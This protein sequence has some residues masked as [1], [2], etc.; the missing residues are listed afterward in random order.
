MKRVCNVLLILVLA[1]NTI[2][3][4][5]GV[6]SA[7]DIDLEK[8]TYL[9]LGKVIEQVVESNQLYQFTQ[10]MILNESITIQE[11]T[12]IYGEKVGDAVEIQYADT[13]I[14]IPLN[15]LQEVQLTESAPE[16]IDSE[17]IEGQVDSLK[18]SKDTALYSINP[19]EMKRILITEEI[20]YPTSQKAEGIGVVYLGNVEFYLSKEDRQVV[21][22][23][24]ANENTEPNTEVS[25][26]PPKDSTSD[27]EKNK[28]EVN[29]DKKE[30]EE[31]PIENNDQQPQEPL[32]NNNDE[33]TN[34]DIEKAEEDKHTSLIEDEKIPSKDN[35]EDNI[36]EKQFTAFS[37]KSEKTSEKTLANT[38]SWEGVSAS[39]FKVVEEKV[40]VY[41]KGKTKKLGEL[42]KGQV[43]PIDSD[44]G[45]WH[46]IQFGM[47]VG[48][49]LKQRTIPDDGT[50]LQN[51]NASYTHSKRTF[52]TSQETP[53]YDNSTGKLVEF[54]IIQ[55]N[56]EYPIVSDY[57]NNWLR[58]VF[59]DR[60]G[61]VLKSQVRQ[62]FD[63]GERYFRV[64]TSNLPVYDNRS[65]SLKEVGTLTKGQTY[66]RVSDYGNWHRIKFNNHYGYVYKGNTEPSSGN[67]IKN[68]NTSYNH[69]NRSF[70]TL[71]DVIV[72]DN[73][74]GKLKAFGTIEEG[75]SYYIASNYGNWWR[76]VF[77]N[78]VGYVLKS[79]I[80]LNFNGEEK[81]FRV[82]TSNLPV[83]DNRSGS[84]E[85]VGTLTKG[86][87][88]PIVADYGNW[89]KIQFDNYFGY[90]YK[91]KTEPG[92]SNKIKNLNT[93]Y[94]NT[95]EMFK[96]EKNVVVYD[97]S[98]GTL[99]PFGTIDSNQKYSIVSNYGNWWRIIFADRIG[100]IH[101]NGVKKAFD[102]N[103]DAFMVTENASLNL[104]KDG[105]R[106]RVATLLK[107]NIFERIA[108]YGNWHKV[109]YGDQI[110]YIWKD[111]T[112][113]DT[114]NFKTNKITG[115][116]LTIIDSTV[117]SE[118]NYNNPVAT[119]QAGERISLINI[120][121]ENW[122][123]IELAGRN[124]FVKNENV[125]NTDN[126]SLNLDDHP[127]LSTLK[128]YLIDSPFNNDNKGTPENETIEAAN[129]MLNDKILFSDYCKDPIHNDCPM[130]Y[131]NGIDWTKGEGVDDEHQRSFLRQLH[132]LFFIN[133]LSE[134]Y[135]ITNNKQY[136]D[137]GYEYIQ[138]WRKNN[139]YYKPKHKMAW[140]DEG[141]A[142]RLSTLVNF[143][144]AGKSILTENQK[145]ELFDMMVFHA[146]L[147]AD[148][149]FYSE[150]TNHGM[151]QDEALI[152]FSKYF[153]NEEIF[154]DYYNIAVNRLDNYFE[155]LISD[156]GVHLEHSPSYHQII[157]GSLRSYGNVLEQFGD[158]LTANRL[159]SKYD[160]MVKYATHVIKPDGTWPLIA[161]TYKKDY[162]LHSIW[163]NN[164]YYQY[165]VTNGQS[166]QK[167]VETN[168]VFPDAGYAIFRDKWTNTNEGTYVFFTAAYHTSY[169]KHSD[170]L[171]L[172][173]YNNEDIITEAGPYSY[174]MSDPITKYA[175]SSYAHNTLIVDDKGLPR[176][177]GKYDS[178]YLKEFNTDDDS[179]PSATGVNKRY[180][181]VTHQRKITFNKLNGIIQVDDEITSNDKHNYK[182]LWHLAPDII[183]EI[184]YDKN[185]IEL[186]KFGKTLMRI[187][188]NSDIPVKISSVYGNED[189]IYKSWSFDY[190][191]EHKKVMRKDV[192]SLIVE[193]EED[194]GFVQTSFK[195]INE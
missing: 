179:K 98:S 113:P 159:Y 84:L 59:T 92:V 145:L 130:D 182:L 122:S 135:N 31:T 55:E 119:I 26:E 3:Q 193:F 63:G 150:N 152:V 190:D 51:E 149:N 8:Q 7:Q 107:G 19:D 146:D 85:K 142:R 151:F 2:L 106:V 96:T 127:Y 27:E 71:K 133:D 156:D 177:D 158:S 126:F 88:Y 6:I 155:S 148:E 157:A 47:S 13:H 62:T 50:N 77:A 104:I 83:Y 44:Y 140:H 53:V 116:L 12:F 141:T 30:T 115:S 184:N 169:H 18:L 82:L 89:H 9:K 14:T 99:V 176:V 39:Y 76:I 74:S 15:N 191:Y 123:E 87:T 23:G 37:A 192:H 33:V 194:K 58:V 17:Q 118:T 166:G 102:E 195:L 138:N 16:F 22:K 160:K 111:A 52:V 86:Q 90:V 137:K 48:Y 172:W 34:K 42:K 5:S 105:V 72:Y 4:T 1:F 170:D 165:A 108:D 10:T 81:Y 91:A 46:Q 188:I 109:K 189:E 120:V 173:I 100:Y 56:E 11:N 183:P 128:T 69:T 25:K 153:Y 54:G 45:N 178:T 78:R 168:V 174:T 24:S 94:K 117:Y 101:K 187:N 66:E 95:S 40:T 171:S 97:N 103:S 57:G 144:E 60:V 65:G 43:Y 110:G 147:L 164:S 67:R 36:Q 186:N 163:E 93:G 162:P 121:D 32:S 181:G 175:Y 185:E 131:T 114:Y 35:K 80:K 143:F 49:V 129:L 124:V 28:E 68:N 139:P 161:D 79:Q 64:L 132:G 134:A 180:E 29:N 167:P 70:T 41:S 136:I 20:E 38:D 154:N 73:S 112:K 21:A 125:I 75:Q 61:Y